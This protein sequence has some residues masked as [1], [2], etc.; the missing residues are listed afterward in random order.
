MKALKEKRLSLR[1]FLRRGLVIL[2]LFALVFAS[3]NTTD[4]DDPGTPGTDP[5]TTPSGPVKSVVSI[6]ITEQPTGLSYQGDAPN[7][8]GMSIEV[9]YAYDGV[10]D[11]TPTK[12]TS[13]SNSAIREL[14]FFASPDYCDRPGMHPSDPVESSGADCGE[15]SLAYGNPGGILLSVNELEIPGVVWL[16]DVSASG[17][18]VKFYADKKPDFTGITLNYSYVYNAAKPYADPSS[19][20]IGSAGSTVTATR[21]RKATTAYPKWDVSDAAKGRVKV[22]IGTAT[23]SAKLVE[24]NVTVTYYQISRVEWTSQTGTFYMYDDDIK[25]ADDSDGANPKTSLVSW[26]GTANPTFTVYYVDS[27]AKP[28]DN[29]TIGWSE[30]Q[31]NKKYAKEAAKTGAGGVIGGSTFYSPEDAI[32]AY[33]DLQEDP[34]ESIN[35]TK[36]GIQKLL[37]YSEDTTWTF[38]MEYVPREYIA[39]PLDAYTSTFDV[40]VPV[41]V[42][43]ELK[44]AERRDEEYFKNNIWARYADPQG[45]MPEEL[46]T[47]INFRWKFTATY[48]SAGGVTPDPKI[49]SATKSSFYLANPEALGGVGAGTASIDLRGPA[50]FKDEVT[51]VLGGSSSGMAVSREWKLPVYYRGA[52]IEDDDGVWVDLFVRK[53]GGTPAP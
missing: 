18:T 1:S 52:T 16:D 27:F 51:A 8:S 41:A 50:E 53:D 49:F 22:Q 37:K 32:F 36:G 11:K 14:G 42:F 43:S 21:T 12:Y 15:F 46:L 39:N 34:D 2:S 25:Y 6:L 9:V 29:R 3:C 20:T 26:V 7:L 38:V 19:M 45:A 44:P 40:E 13:V 33:G 24:R 5:G 23:G 10:P 4:P 31:E 47:A 48:E 17:E 28:V 30:F 35:I